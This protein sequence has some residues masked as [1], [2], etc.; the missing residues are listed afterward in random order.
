M[1]NV[2]EVG[3]PL[4]PGRG[5][6]ASL[7][8]DCLV[9]GWG[10]WL[11][12]SPQALSGACPWGLALD[13]SL[14]PADPPAPGFPCP[15]CVPQSHSHAAP[16][17]PSFTVSAPDIVGAGNLEGDP[18]PTL[19]PP[20]TCT[21]SCPPVPHGTLWHPSTPMVYHDT[22]WP[23]STSQY[24]HD[25]PSTPAGPTVSP[26]CS[27]HPQHPA[28]LPWPVLPHLSGQALAAISILSTPSSLC[29]LVFVAPFY[30]K[31]ATCIPL[32]AGLMPC[33]PVSFR[34]PEVLGTCDSWL[35]PGCR[36]TVG[37]GAH[38][39]VLDAGPADV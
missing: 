10:G 11:L 28:P 36:A 3:R 9:P 23:P 20:L 13:P 39:H 37:F 12:P 29:N 25:I 8:H 38:S 1:Q 5:C 26:W 35:Q 15:K 31:G 24:S 19:D 21:P 14:G 18:G 7:G 17:C 4:G 30:P 27:Q 33:S 6:S 16:C 2:L 22:P 32:S 34:H